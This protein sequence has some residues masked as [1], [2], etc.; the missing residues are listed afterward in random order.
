[1]AKSKLKFQKLSDEI[2]TRTTVLSKE[3]EKQVLEELSKKY[4]RKVKLVK[5]FAY[6][7]LLMQWSDE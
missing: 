7:P 1:M 6:I 2:I 3:K 5:V 4:G